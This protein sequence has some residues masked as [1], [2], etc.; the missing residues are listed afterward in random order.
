MDQE[1][2][3]NARQKL[4]TA[5]DTL[6]AMFSPDL[7]D[8]GLSQNERIEQVFSFESDYISGTL[9]VGTVYEM[10]VHL[11]VRPNG[12]PSVFMCTPALNKASPVAGMALITDL[13]TACEAAAQMEVMLA[14]MLAEMSQEEAAAAIT[15]QHQRVERSSDATQLN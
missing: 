6:T 5:L 7:W 11:V 2:T 12:P 14:D 15:A 3:E 4:V 13:R 1:T 8:E 10:H 9:H